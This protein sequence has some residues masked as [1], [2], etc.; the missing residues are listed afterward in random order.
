MDWLSLSSWIMISGLIFKGGM[1]WRSSWDF[2]I[3][4]ELFVNSQKARKEGWEVTEEE[5]T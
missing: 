3:F 5:K 2:Y 4:D 1:K